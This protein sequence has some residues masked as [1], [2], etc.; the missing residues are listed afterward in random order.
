MSEFFLEK[1]KIY[2]MQVSSEPAKDM[3][4]WDFISQSMT[5]SAEVT[6]VVVVITRITYCSQSK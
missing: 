4:E 1:S 3:K 2:N 5:Q 6:C